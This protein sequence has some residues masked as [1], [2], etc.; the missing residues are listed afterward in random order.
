MM[1]WMFIFS[2][3]GAVVAGGVMA[4]KGSRDVCLPDKGLKRDQVKT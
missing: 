3:Y 1:L 2:R 4:D